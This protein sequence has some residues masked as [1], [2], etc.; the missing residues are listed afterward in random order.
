[1][2]PLEDWPHPHI[3][4]LGHVFF[5]ELDQEFLMPPLA[6]AVP[7]LDLDPPVR[8]LPAI[9]TAARRHQRCDHHH[10]AG[11]S[12]GQRPGLATLP[13]L[14]HTH[15]IAVPRHGRDEA[16]APG[17]RRSPPRNRR[18]AGHGVRSER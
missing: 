2:E 1:M 10:A 18:R 3:G 7:E 16:L 11:H 13:E 12:A 17:I 15:K 8:R 4:M 9:G 5:R 14:G 6:H